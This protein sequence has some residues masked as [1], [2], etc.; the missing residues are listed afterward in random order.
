MVVI[1]QFS[2]KKPLLLMFQGS[3][4]S[5]GISFEVKY[6]LLWIDFE[7][8]GIEKNAR[9]IAVTFIMSFFFTPFRRKKW[10]LGPLHIITCFVS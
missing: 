1:I 2:F 4:K 6:F 10:Y 8:C 3:K 5:T 9:R 7:S